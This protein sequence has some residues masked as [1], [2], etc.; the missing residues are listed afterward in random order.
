MTSYSIEN[1]QFK[2]PFTCMVAGPTGSGKTHLVRDMLRYYDYIFTRLNKNKINV[3]WLHGQY[4]NLYSVPVAPQVNIIYVDVLQKGFPSMNDI[5]GK[6][7]DLIVI[8]DLMNEMGK[9]VRV[10]NLF[11]KGSHHMNISVIF[12]VQNVFHQS[13][14]MRTISLNAHYIVIMKN[15]RDRN[16]ILVLGRQIFPMR[17]KFFV[18]CYEDATS[19]PFGYI[20]VDLTPDTKEDLRLQSNIFPIYDKKD[21]KYILSPTIYNFK[22]K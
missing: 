14:V 3:L 12:I 13:P 20:R 22:R 17:S 6:N 10:S 16:Q 7:I 8:D 11:T 4:Q 9:D 15:T 1:F 2:H 21:K 18:E 5:Q 19:S